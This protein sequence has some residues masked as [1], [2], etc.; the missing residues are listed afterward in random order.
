MQE[1]ITSSRQSQALG[2]ERQKPW[3]RKMGRGMLLGVGEQ[4]VLNLSGAQT[5]D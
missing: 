5:W 1:P 2:F 4:M 3:T